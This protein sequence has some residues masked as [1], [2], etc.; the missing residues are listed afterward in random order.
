[1]A[2][3][4]PTCKGCGNRIVWRRHERT[5]K[6]APIDAEA[7]VDGNI[8]IVDGETYRIDKTAAGPRFTNHWATCTRPPSKGR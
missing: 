1:M 4:G 3:Y 6:L 7:T 2:S 8:V 5:G